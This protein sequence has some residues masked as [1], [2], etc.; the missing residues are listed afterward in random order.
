MKFVV[1]TLNGI[2]YKT[3][4]YNDA[5]H[6]HD[7]VMLHGEWVICEDNVLISGQNVKIIVPF[8]E[9]TK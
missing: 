3:V 1:E 7:N 5:R 6:L 8:T 4:D 9:E 2:T